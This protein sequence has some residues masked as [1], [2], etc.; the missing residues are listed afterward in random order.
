MSKIN[1]ESATPVDGTEPAQG[2]SR[3]LLMISLPLVLIA[4]AAWY[5][6]AGAGT[7]STDNAYVRQ[8]KVSVSADVS[9]RIAKV[10]VAENQQVA[11]GALLFEV[12]Q[13]TYRIAL[14]QA[15]AALATARLDVSQ[16]R[17]GLA[18][19]DVSIKGATEDV[20][21]AQQDLARQQ[22]LLRE[23]FTTRARFDQASHALAQAREALAHATAET[24]NAA[25]ALG[26]ASRP[27]GQHPL[28][29]AALAKRNRAALDLALTSVRAPA[30]GTVSQT[31]RLQVGTV[32]AVG[33]P[34]LTIVRSGKPWIEANFKETD[35]RDMAVGQSAE[36]ELDAYGKGVLHG[37]V[38]SIGAGT[39]S[40]FSVLPAQNASGNWVKVTQRVPV[41]IELIETPKRELIAGLSAKVTVMTDK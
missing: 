15:E 9:G 41:R 7:V 1:T 11:K 23:G 40:E 2:R 17:T 16:L 25:A 4:L 3:L 32:A 12:E 26:D 5:Y 39:G 18:T 31:G 27:D 22:Q 29:L 8:D 30:N 14:A 24:A 21:F 34:M 6:L 33:L 37:R 20:A 19:K 35:L 13:A 10:A 28:I 38:A 36:I